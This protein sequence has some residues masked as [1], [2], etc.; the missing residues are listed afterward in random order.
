MCRGQRRAATVATPLAAAF[1]LRPCQEIT[2]SILTLQKV[3]RPLLKSQSGSDRWQ[4]VIAEGANITQ[5]SRV[6]SQRAED[7]AFHLGQ[8]NA[9]RKMR[10]T[11][12]PASALR[13]RERRAPLLMDFARSTLEVRCVPASLSIAATSQSDA[14]MPAHTAGMQ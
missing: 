8:A 9:L 6:R 1:S 12:R 7:N 10:S 3:D 5:Q 14:R 4:R 13:G 2:Q 11:H